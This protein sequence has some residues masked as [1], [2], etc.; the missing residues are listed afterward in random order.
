MEQQKKQKLFLVATGLFV[1]I[2]AYF[3]IDIMMVTTPP[4]KKKKIILSDSTSSTKLDSVYLANFE[5]TLTY[6]Y[7][8]GKNEVLGK[9]A[10]KFNVKID[11][12]KAMNRLMDNNIIE[13]QALKVRV[14][15]LHRV[16][17][18]EMVSLIAKK[19]GIETQDI[20]QA[21]NIRNARQVWA[22]QI[23]VIPIPSK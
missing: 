14:R 5:D 12:L 8:V 4:W 1:G 20:L 3:V 21:N 13:N 15:A 17:Q 18:G 19:Y 23:L 7:R 2:V 16:K 10:E 22:D 9:I 6:I 11:T